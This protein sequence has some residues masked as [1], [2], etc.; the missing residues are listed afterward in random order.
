MWKLCEWMQHGSAYC[1]EK[2]LISLSLLV[3]Q[4]HQELQKQHNTP[5]H[6]EERERKGKRRDQFPVKQ[7]TCKSLVL[8]SFFLWEKVV[9]CTLS[10]F[11]FRPRR[12][13]TTYSHI[14][15]RSLSIRCLGLCLPSLGLVLKCPYLIGKNN[16]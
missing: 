9:F 13:V 11:N 3:C 1:W 2:Y 8:F 12:R 10:S 14:V 15:W 4:K 6:N 5:R 7:V 16:S